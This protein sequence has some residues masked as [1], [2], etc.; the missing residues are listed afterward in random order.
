MTPIALSQEIHSLTP[1][2]I[3]HVIP[4]YGHLPPI[5]KPEIVAALLKELLARR[6]V[7]DRVQNR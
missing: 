1:G 6:S 7:P 4:D 5:E 3:F 2:S